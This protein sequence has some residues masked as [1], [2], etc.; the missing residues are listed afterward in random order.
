MSDGRFVSACAITS[1][2]P[3]NDNLVPENRTEM[4]QLGSELGELSPDK[5]NILVNATSMNVSF[6]ERLECC[7]GETDK[8]YHSDYVQTL[9][10]AEE[11]LPEC[12][13]LH[14]KIA[15]E[16]IAAVVDSGCQLSLLNENVY[17]KLKLGGLKTSR[18]ADSTCNFG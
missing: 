13:K 11:K 1:D 4:T 18:T 5:I 14:F 9:Y 2:E 3:N 10:V 6:E 7:R 12:P 16:E 17:N 8:P 15:G